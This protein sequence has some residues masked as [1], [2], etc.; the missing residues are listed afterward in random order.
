MRYA[1]L[2]YVA[3][4]LV[5][6]VVAQSHNKNDATFWGTVVD[7]TG[8]VVP[9]TKVILKGHGT[10]VTVTDKEG[11]FS[12]DGLRTGWYSLRAEKPNFK[13]AALKGI[14]IK[15]GKTYALQVRLE[16]GRIVDW[17]ILT[18]QPITIDPTSSSPHSCVTDAEMQSVPMDRSVTG[19][20]SVAGRCP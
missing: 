3:L 8:A 4:L 17:I 15:K 19:A 1:G 13:T 18:D 7:E 11:K 2:V 6:T 14:E 12:F 5:G 16:T 9:G 20:I 10:K